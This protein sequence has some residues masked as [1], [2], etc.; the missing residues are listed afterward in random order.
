MEQPNEPL[1]ITK[2]EKIDYFVGILLG[3]ATILGALSANYATLWGGNQSQSYVKG[4]ITMSQANTNYLEA[5][6]DYSDWEAT[7][8]KDDFLQVQWNDAVRRNNKEESDY[9]ESKMSEELQRI[10]TASDDSAEIAALEYDKANEL[11][12]E[13]YEEKMDSAIV[14]NQEARKYVLNG[15]KAN[16]NGDKFTFV[17]VLFT[18]VLFF[19]GM[20]AITRRV[21]L[22]S[23]YFGIAILMFI[24]SAIRMFMIPFP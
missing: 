24:Y 11:K 20:A 23:I 9:Y 22:K 7:D 5:L 4:I 19:G 6:N 1:P 16:E 3:I 2:G 13:E 17:T 18:V 10:Y 21:Q 8:F 14:M 15:D 12:G